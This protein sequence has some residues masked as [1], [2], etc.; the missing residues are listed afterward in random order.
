MIFLESLPREMPRETS[1][2]RRLFYTRC[3]KPVLYEGDC[4]ILDAKSLFY[5]KDLA[6]GHI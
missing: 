3:E 4:F 5:A 1:M 2:R 6:L